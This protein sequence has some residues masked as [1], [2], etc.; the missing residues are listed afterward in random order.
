MKLAVI[1]CGDV[2]KSML[3]L[4]KLTKGIKITGV[5]D[6]DISKAKKTAARFKNVPAFSD[7]KKM[8]ETV[9]SDAV[10]IAVPHFLHYPIMKEVIGYKKHILCE[11][12]ITTNTTDAYEIIK[13]A[14]KNNIKVGINYQYRYDNACYKLVMAAKNKELGNINFGRVLIPWKRENEYFEQ[15][16]WHGSIKKAGGGTLITQGSHLLDIILWIFDNK[17]ISIN[18]KSKNYKFN[19]IEV[20][21]FISIELEFENGAII[22]II[23]TMASSK[24]KAVSIELY[25]EKAIGTYKGYSGFSKVSFTKKNINKYKHKI[26]AIHP[27]QRSLIAF[28]DWVLKDEKYLNEAKEAVKVLKLI[29]EIYNIANKA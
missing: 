18:A 27:F 28:R 4:S 29:E 10:Y 2:T 6:I 22:Q 5:S 21:D 13:L 20:E 7:Y 15:S 14:E 1:G 9:E 23:S 26:F 8:L 25:G 11:K 24:E 16:K 19:K 12:P 17:V 3:M